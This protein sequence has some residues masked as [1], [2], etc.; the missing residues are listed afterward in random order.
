[1]AMA[2]DTTAILAAWGQT[3]TVVR[4]SNSY[5]ATGGATP[6][7]SS[8]GS[9][10]GMI[11]PLGGTLRS[12]NVGDKD[13]ATHEVYLPNSTTVRAGDRVRPA[14]WA[15]GDDEYQVLSAEAYSPSHTRLFCKLVRG[16]GG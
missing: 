8:Q 15:A 2:D 12:G 6:S 7:W 4:T 5:G 9:A 14:A 3:L 16:H 1:M 13:A 11:Q 10:T